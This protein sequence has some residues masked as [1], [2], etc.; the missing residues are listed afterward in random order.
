MTLDDYLKVYLLV[1]RFEVQCA[2]EVLAEVVGPVLF[3]SIAAGKR[4]SPYEEAWR[5]DTKR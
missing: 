4:Q 5:R 2:S 1:S 3:D